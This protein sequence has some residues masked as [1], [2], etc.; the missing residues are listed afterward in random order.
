MVANIFVKHSYIFSFLMAEILL[1]SQKILFLGYLLSIFLI[2]TSY[3][4]EKFPPEEDRVG[5]SY[6]EGFR[7]YKNVSAGQIKLIS[8]LAQSLKEKPV[9]S[10]TFNFSFNI[11]A[12]LD[13]KDI[14]IFIEDRNKESYYMIPIQKKWPSGLQRF[15]WSSEKAGQKGIGINDLFGLTKSKDLDL[16]EMILPIKLYYDEESTQIDSYEF[17]FVA[18]RRATVRYSIFDESEQKVDFGLFKNQPR[19]KNIIIKWDCKGAKPGKYIL[20]AKYSFKNGRSVQGEN[21]YQF[22]HE[23]QKLTSKN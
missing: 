11:P 22:Y 3:S 12:E 16:A 23:T 8:F 14:D 19:N 20:L 9:N 5:S 18:T 7:R 17:V 2:T 6:Y 4:Q 10:S 15:S 21:T 1:M 13:N